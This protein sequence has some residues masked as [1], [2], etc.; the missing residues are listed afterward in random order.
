MLGERVPTPP[1]AEAW[2]RS[3]SARPSSALRRAGTSGA[4]RR[5][6]LATVLDDPREFAL[7]DHGAAADFGSVAAGPVR[8]RRELSISEIHT[9]AAGYVRYG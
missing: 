1:F 7:S 2:M 5:R 4:A 3:A 9:E 8:A 6:R